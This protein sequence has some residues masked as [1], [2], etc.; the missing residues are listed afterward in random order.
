[1]KRYLEY[2]SENV[3]YELYYP[4]LDAPGL[5]EEAQRL[6]FSAPYCGHQHDCCGC[7]C[8]QHAKVKSNNTIQI[9]ELYN[10]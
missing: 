1:M 8:G 7:F 5:K 10:Y 4:G 9:R 6:T 3:V 2:N